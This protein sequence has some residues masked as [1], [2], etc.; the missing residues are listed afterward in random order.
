MEKKKEERKEKNTK[1]KKKKERR[2]LL[3]VGISKH[4]TT[5]I[6]QFIQPSILR[7]QEGKIV[8]YLIL[9]VGIQVILVALLALGV[10]CH[11]AKA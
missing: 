5:V 3:L 9:G 11:A 7:F 2:P 8:I 6:K 4:I 1:K 10:V